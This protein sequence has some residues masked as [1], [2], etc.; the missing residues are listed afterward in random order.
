M[1]AQKRR[2][3]KKVFFYRRLALFIGVLLFLFVI[4]M[5][6]VKLFTIKHI[7]VEGN[8]NASQGEIDRIAEE[9]MNKNYFFS[10]KGKIEKQMVQIPFVESA[11]ISYGFPQKAKIHL[12]EEIP[13]FQVSNKN[14]YSLINE[15][16]EII[17]QTKSFL[18]SVPTIEGLR[19]EGIKV[20]ENLFQ[21]SK[22][23]NRKEF[24]HN[25]VGSKMHKEINTIRIMEQ[26][27]QIMTKDDLRIVFRSFQNSQYKLE[28]LEKIYNEI[29][30]SD[31]SF[32]TILMDQSENPVAIRGER[33]HDLDEFE[34]QIGTEENRK[35]KTENQ[36]E[37][38]KNVLEENGKNQEQNKQENQK[39]TTANDEEE[40][41]NQ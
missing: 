3:R 9:M 28:Q 23:K 16:L 4:G 15:D 35:E 22:N 29:R 33:N 25:L 18:S 39:E 19:G 24:F 10:G 11:K 32:H 34:D 38:N 37:E 26:G 2:R 30:K 40:E 31:E 21:D 41:R 8:I 27:V 20:G 1:N 14:G 5:G 6:L 7:E 36:S 12:V 17:S 13:V